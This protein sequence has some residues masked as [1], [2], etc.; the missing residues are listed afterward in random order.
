MVGG[1]GG[2]ARTDAGRA[3]AASA[4]VA[5]SGRWQRPRWIVCDAEVSLARDVGRGRRGGRQRRARHFGQR[6][7]AQRVV[8]E[9]R[10][11]IRHSADGRA[12]ECDRTVWDGVR[13]AHGSES[14]AP[15]NALD[16]FAGNMLL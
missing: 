11:R 6:S 15:L 1:V 16:W 14:R 13:C 7:V 8:Q 10:H 5:Q 9:R 2:I 3:Y 12:Y 4:A